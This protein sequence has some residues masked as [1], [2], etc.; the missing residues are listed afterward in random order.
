MSC[1]KISVFLFGIFLL[2]CLPRDQQLQKYLSGLILLAA[3]EYC[4][5]TPRL[6][7]DISPSLIWLSPKDRN[8]FIRSSLYLV[9][10]YQLVTTND[11]AYQDNG[12]YTI[13]VL[14]D[15][16]SVELNIVTKL[17]FHILYQYVQSHTSF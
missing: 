8:Y 14:S 12:R 13:V 5:V 11:R 16:S 2:D 9:Y 4:E 1:Y 10:G 7:Q 15:L 3:R 17:Q 6:N